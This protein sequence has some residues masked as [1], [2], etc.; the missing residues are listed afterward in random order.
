[1]SSIRYVY[2]AWIV[3]DADNRC[4][5][6]SEGVLIAETDK[7]YKFAIEATIDM[8]PGFIGTEVKLGWADVTLCL[9][10]IKQYLPNITLMLDTYH[11]YVGTKGNSILS[12]DFGKHWHLVKDHFRGAIYADTE[13]KCLVSSK[14]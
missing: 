6:V 12:K 5:P 2:F 14:H 1:M 7:M 8:T 11:F 10:K 3:I 13:Q 9:N 4:M